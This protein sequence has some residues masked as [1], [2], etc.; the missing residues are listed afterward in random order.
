VG[1]RGWQRRESS[2]AASRRRPRRTPAVPHRRRRDPPP[3]SPPR[4]YRSMLVSSTN[5]TS[6]KFVK[7]SPPT[8]SLEGVEAEREVEAGQVA[9]GVGVFRAG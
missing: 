1:R 7:P 6:P 4:W 9:Q 8:E 2:R 5:C 3:A